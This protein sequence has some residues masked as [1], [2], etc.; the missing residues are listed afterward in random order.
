MWASRTD[1]KLTPNTLSQQLE[2]RRRAGLPILDLTESNPTRCGLSYPD[3]ILSVLGTPESLVYEPSPKGMLPARQ[4]VAAYYASKG[5]SVDPDQIIL[6]ASTSEAYS[7][8][9]RLLA[10]PGDCVLVPRPSYPLLDFLATINDVEL[11][12]YP[13]VYSGQW[14]IDL[15]DIHRLITARTRAIVV[16]SP[17]NP[18]GSWLHRQELSELVAACRAHGLALICDEVFADYPFSTNADRVVT[19]VG[20]TDV[21]A[22]ALGGISKLLGLPQ[23]KLAWLCASGP[24]GLLDEALAR[25]EVIADTYLSVNTPVQHAL[26]RWMAQRVRLS[27]PILSRVLVNRQYLLNRLKATSRCECLD[28]EGGWYAVIRVPCTYPE[29]ELVL[30]LLEQD[31]V[32]I[33]P[34]YFFDFAADGYLVASLLP[35]PDVFEAGIEKI[36]H[37]VGD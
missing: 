33:H 3:D 10:N 34:G 9:F 13:L 7:F 31:G 24:A 27:Q 32:L 1:W 2:A 22:F 36:L 14:H 12:A 35:P 26:P 15:T 37:R 20:A 25:L 5:V 6:T 16:V 18:T 17:N 11:V 21:L 29:E 19:M 8:L 28:A 23:M 30:T 4:A